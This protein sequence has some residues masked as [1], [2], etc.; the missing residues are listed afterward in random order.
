LPTALRDPRLSGAGNWLAKRLTQSLDGLA[1]LANW[2]RTPGQHE[3]T[4]RDCEILRPLLARL[5]DEASLVAELV[6]GPAV[7]PERKLR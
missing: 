4:P 7:A 5:G 3:L 2:L 1:R 6:L